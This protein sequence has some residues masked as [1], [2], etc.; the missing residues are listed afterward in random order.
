MLLF[1]ILGIAFTALFSLRIVPQEGPLKSSPQEESIKPCKL[2]PPVHDRFVQKDLLNF[3]NDQI[4]AVPDSLQVGKTGRGTQS[5][6]S[7][8]VDATAPSPPNILAQTASEDVNFHFP[9]VISKAKAF[10]DA[11]ITV[12]FKAIS[13]KIDQAAGI[14]FRFLDSN[15]YYV[16][17]ANALEN[18]IILFKFV[19]GTRLTVTSAAVPVSSG[20][21]HSLRVMLVGDCVRGYLDGKLLIEI[22]DS[23]FREGSVGLWTKADSVTYFDNLIIEY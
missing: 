19:D 18:N 7:A 23:T 12:S 22:E 21:W 1:L 2:A 3:D 14:I 16:L 10:R 13:G 4:G 8:K 17:R 11:N 5:H 15:N 20:E 6:W 9:Y